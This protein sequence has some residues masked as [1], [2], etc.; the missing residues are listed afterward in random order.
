MTTISSSYPS[1]TLPPQVQGGIQGDISKTG[2]VSARTPIA[3]TKTGM[4]A[5]PQAPLEQAEMVNPF[6]ASQ[7]AM[8]KGSNIQVGAQLSIRDRNGM[9]NIQDGDDGSDDGV[10]NF[11]FV[12][13]E[14]A[15]VELSVDNNQAPD[16]SFK[17]ASGAVSDVSAGKRDAFS[18]PP[19]INLGDNEG[20]G[21]L[22]LSANLS[23]EQIDHYR[24]VTGNNL[25]GNVGAGP[26]DPAGDRFAERLISGRVS[27]DEAQGLFD[28]VEG[29]RQDAIAKVSSKLTDVINDLRDMPENGFSATASGV[30]PSS[31]QRQNSDTLKQLV[32]AGQALQQKFG[33]YHKAMQE[34]YNKGVDPARL[35]D[36][37]TEGRGQTGITD[38]ENQISAATDDFYKSAADL[39][40]K[41][42]QALNK[43]IDAR[44]TKATLDI[45]QSVLGVVS[46]IGGLAIGTVTALRGLGRLVDAKVAEKATGHVVDVARKDFDSTMRAAAHNATRA[47]G[48]R[49][50]LQA[51]DRAKQKDAATRLEQAGKMHEEAQDKLRDSW[52]DTAQQSAGVGMGINGTVSDA[53]FIA[54]RHEGGRHGVRSGAVDTQKP[55]AL[56][57]TQG[58]LSALH[59]GTGYKAFNEKAAGMLTRE[60]AYDPK[61]GE[62]SNA[63]SSY[64]EYEDSREDFATVP[65]PLQ[66][67]RKLEQNMKEAAKL[68]DSA[69]LGERYFVI[70][71]RFS[72]GHLRQVAFHTRI[73]KVSNWPLGAAPLRIG[74]NPD[75]F[76]KLTYQ[77]RSRPAGGFN[78]RLYF[79]ALSGES[80]S[81]VSREHDRYIPAQFDPSRYSA[82]YE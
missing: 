38:L 16:F 13:D 62:N 34:A 54:Q 4:R 41:N 66:H 45:L 14:N 69:E 64:S 10:F 39:I 15:T 55:A 5:A 11:D 53:K 18:R 35:I 36:I 72:R 12:P 70:D 48:G 78:D 81:R 24:I 44:D 27:A 30:D 8:L 75:V 51:A 71:E 47:G 32:A 21:D 46:D 42:D 33:D 31:V 52:R 40:E 43:T 1:T 25:V 37:V 23:Q 65:V 59:K 76:E 6:D 50:H 7:R 22:S 57:E 17:L 26:G 49:W 29:H 56:L 20:G 68:N 63:F 19:A 3:G 2:P 60:I 58:E 79:R 77:T 67:Q 73:V 74:N 61:S 9:R 28:R 80:R 82:D